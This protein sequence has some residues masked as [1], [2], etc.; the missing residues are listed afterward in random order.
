MQGQQ[1]ELRL[2]RREKRCW[3]EVEPGKGEERCFPKCFFI[4]YLGI[5][6]SESVVKILC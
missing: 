3:T 2:G 6:V 5:S 1:G 4:C